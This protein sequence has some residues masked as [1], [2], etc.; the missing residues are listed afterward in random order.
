LDLLP[1]AIAAKHEVLPLMRTDTALTVAMADPTNVSAIHDVAFITNLHV[2]PVVASRTAIRQAIERNY[3][4]NRIADAVSDLTSAASE[5]GPIDGVEARGTADAFELRDSVDDPPIVRLVST[6]LI[7][8][9]E[10]GASDVHWEPYESVFRLRLRIDGILHELSALPKRLEAA[11]ISRLKIMA[12]MDIAER[13]LPQDGRIRLRVQGKEIDLR[14][15]TVPTMHGESVVMRILDKGGV[16]LDFAKL[17]FADDTLKSFLDVLMQP[18]GVLLVTGP[19]GSGKTTTLYTALERLNQPD[20][21]ILTV[22]DP[23]EYELAGVAQIPVRPSRGFTFATGLRSILRQDPDVVMVGEI[24]D[25]E[26]AEIAIRAALTGHQVF[27]TLHT[28][29]SAGAITRLLD[30][31]VEA[32]L[33]S[34]SLEGVLAQRLVRRICAACR[35]EWQV[36]AAVLQKME[37]FGAGQLNERSYRGAGCEECRRTGYRRRVGVFELLAISAELRELILQRRSSAELKAAA[38]KSMITIQQDALRKA[39][40]GITTL[41]EVLRVV[42]GDAVE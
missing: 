40:D 5:L 1:A 10:R 41:E 24:R 32:F 38:R 23:V 9:I 39:A 30:M 35:E 36:P 12:S 26:T 29:D 17:G 34:S 3:H 14:V 22:E 2:M 25:S 6:I 33:I 16:A 20:V 11:V 27:S 4:R 28:N 19:T 37:D 42:S 31:G 21:K 7:D 13:R 18:H 8:A 15:S